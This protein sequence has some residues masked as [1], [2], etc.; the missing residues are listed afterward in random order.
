MEAGSEWNKDRDRWLSMNALFWIVSL[1]LNTP[2]QVSGGT[3]SNHERIYNGW[4]ENWVER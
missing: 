2:K 1:I 3:W 4:F